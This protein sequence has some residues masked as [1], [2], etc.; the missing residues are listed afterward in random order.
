M[1]PVVPVA[2]PVVTEITPDPTS[3]QQPTGTSGGGEA[4]LPDNTPTEVSTV[5]SVSEAT[6]PPP[7]ETQITDTTGYNTPTP[8]PSPE[9]TFNEPSPQIATNPAIVTATPVTQPTT[10]S[11]VSGT[12]TTA[13]PGQ[14]NTF[15]SGDTFNLTVTGT[16]GQPVYVVQ[17]GGAPFLFGYVG[18]DGTFVAPPTKWDDT[19][20]G[21]YTQAWIVGQPGSTGANTQTIK[22][23]ITGQGGG[24]TTITDNHPG[25]PS[26][27]ANPGSTVI[28]TSAT[29][30]AAATPSQYGNFQVGDQFTAKITGKPGDPVYVT[31]TKNGTTSAPYYYGVIGPD[32]IFIPPY[33]SWGA[34]DAGVYSQTWAVGSNPP[35]TVNFTIGQP[36][37]PLDPPTPPPPPPTVTPIVDAPGVNP[38]GPTLTNDSA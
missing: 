26:S 19:N 2:E 6:D 35:S 23:A 11:L 21:T 24:S 7:T 36:T 15:H 32:G 22:F 38:A 14:Y 33:Y 37:I 9:P 31:Q 27:G 30:G 20:I 34:G 5:G 1:D 12:G 16:P 25:Q 18:A 29:A 4:T 10:V 8:A 3:G 13:Q 17:N 28:V